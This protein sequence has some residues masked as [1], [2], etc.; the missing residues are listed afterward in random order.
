MKFRIHKLGYYNNVG[1]DDH[2]HHHRHQNMHV[3]KACTLRKRGTVTS[4]A[5]ELNPRVKENMAG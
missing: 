2:H 1:N 3:I 5:L 4:H